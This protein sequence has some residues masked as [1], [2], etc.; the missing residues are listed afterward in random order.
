MYTLFWAKSLFIKTNALCGNG[1]KH[2]PEIYWELPIFSSAAVISY[3]FSKN[4]KDWW[5]SWKRHICTIFLVKTFFPWDWN[6][7]KNVQCLPRKGYISHSQL[8]IFIFPDF[9]FRTY[10]KK[11]INS[12]SNAAISKNTKKKTF[13][14]NQSKNVWDMVPIFLEIFFSLVHKPWHHTFM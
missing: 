2:F 12:T 3:I 4:I 11:I 8:I 6:R 1:S 7:P 10:R 13:F 9:P 5:F 14:L